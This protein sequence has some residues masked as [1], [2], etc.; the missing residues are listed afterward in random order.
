MSASSLFAALLCASFGLPSNAQVSLRSVNVLGSKN[1]VEIEVDASDHVVPQTRILT[2]PDR[3]VIDFPNAIPSPQVRNQSI[4]R[5]DVKDVR[6]GLFRAKPPIARVVLDLKSPRSFQ[7]FPS[8]HQVIIK[9]LGDDA[10]SAQTA[11][12]SQ[13]GPN[14]V[15]VGNSSGEA[16]AVNS[17]PPLQVSYQDRM[18]GIR[19]NKATLSQILQAVQ[20]RTGAELSLAPGADQEQ[21]VAEIAPAPAPEVLARLLNGSQF[22]FLILSAPNDPAQLGRVILTSRP[23]MSGQTI[24]VQNYQPPMPIDTVSPQFQPSQPNPPDMTDHPPGPPGF[25]VPDPPLSNDDELNK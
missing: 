17:I 14:L 13:Q 11:N 10:A 12:P 15:F 3:L 8:A 16:V 9:V 2:G 1:S 18:L 6:V 5:G 20:Q 19:A 24:P 23:D 22:N 4:D 21:V 25:P 7:I